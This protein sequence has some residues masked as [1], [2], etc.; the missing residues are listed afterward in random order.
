MS[1]YKYEARFGF[2]A[3]W[4]AWRAGAA[5]DERQISLTLTKRC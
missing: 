1:T 2:Y 4:R 3:A 5:H